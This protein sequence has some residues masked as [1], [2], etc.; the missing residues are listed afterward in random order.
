MIG[1]GL[2]YMTVCFNFGTCA[3]FNVG[4]LINTVIHLD[5]VYYLY[6]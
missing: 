6:L 1:L 2:L 3:K 4:F 5:R